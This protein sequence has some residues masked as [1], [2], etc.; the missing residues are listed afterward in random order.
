[1]LRKQ[2]YIEHYKYYTLYYV[3]GTQTV[4]DRENHLRQYNTTIL[5]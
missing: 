2:N 5:F 1:M 4:R 3:G